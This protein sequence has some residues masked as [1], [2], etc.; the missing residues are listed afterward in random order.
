[1]SLIETRHLALA[2]LFVC[3]SA[4]AQTIGQ[5]AS[6]VSRIDE[7]LTIRRVAVLPVN[8]N[9]DG[10]YS[11][12]IEAQLINLV[13]SSH[14]WDYVDAS[15]AGGIPT[16]AEM[17]DSPDQVSKAIRG[18]EA[19]A[20]FVAAASRGP[21]GIS[22]RLDLFLKKDGKLL[23]QE[24]LNNHP[25]FEIPQLREQMNT[26][27]GKLV[28]KLPYDGLIL[29]RQGQR[30]T[31]NLGKS[32]GLVKDQIVT[33][34]QII[35]VNRHPKFGFL[36]STEKEILG[37]IKILK[38]DESLSFG[39]I[40]SEKERGAISR[41][42]KISGLD[43]VNYPEPEALGAPSGG[44]VNDRPDAKVTFG[45]DA[46]EWLPVKPPAFG[47]VGLALGFG[48]YQSSVTLDTV[49]SL[50]AQSAFYPSLAAHGELWLNPKWTVRAELAQGVLSTSN[51]RAGS[52]PG[53]LNHS[54]SRYSL[55]MVYNF[56]L[57]DD[58]WGPKIQLSGG[59]ANYRMYVDDSSPQ[60]L[61]TTTFSG[62]MLGLGGS[63]PV[64]EEKLWYVGGK[65]NIFISPSL[66]ETPTASG[67]GGTATVN[68][69]A[70][71]GEKK[72]GENL[73][74]TGALDFSLYSSTFTGY[75]SRVNGAT[76]ETATSLSQKHTIFSG[77]IVYMF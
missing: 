35:S 4:G 1:M 21:N 33:A 30:V 62:F 22:I 71:T 57:R 68:S 49:G 54:M 59:L 63:F 16:V 29:S 13:K 15:I 5:S 72:I 50:E 11:R 60:A 18:I 73:R 52:S 12:P 27:Y 46:R 38:I 9:V 66:S 74:A 8:D 14:R 17:E 20:I 3:T 55:S 6:Y 61:T 47:Q 48:M 53:T 32:D 43:Q 64:N 23:A 37:K 69:F 36:V 45:K 67:S 10:I 40:V 42:A 44:D 34:V 76:P 65:L 56:L 77:G 51:P 24:L 2:I 25:R 26:L 7:D 75:G 41:L 39:A 19:D 31:V 58:F 28:A 70:L